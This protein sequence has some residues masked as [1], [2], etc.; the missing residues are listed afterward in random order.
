MNCVVPA[1]VPPGVQ[2]L[3]MVLGKILFV[4]PIFPLAIKLRLLIDKFVT[5]NLLVMIQ[6][7]L[8][9]RE[10]YPTVQ[11]HVLGIKQ[12]P[13]CLGLRYTVTHLVIPGLISGPHHELKVIP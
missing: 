6:C 5:E 10:E 3:Y 1:D 13:S 2:N 9:C 4:L 12:H 8:V 7:M 11:A